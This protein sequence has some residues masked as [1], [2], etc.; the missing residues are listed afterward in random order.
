M[1]GQEADIAVHFARGGVHMHLA[2][3]AIG[4]LAVGIQRR[5]RSQEPVAL[6]RRK[7]ARILPDA[8]HGRLRAENLSGRLVRGLNHRVAIVRTRLSESSG[9]PEADR[10]TAGRERYL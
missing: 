1:P 10:L 9:D 6:G 2:K 8:H 5:E 3:I 7:R 4:A